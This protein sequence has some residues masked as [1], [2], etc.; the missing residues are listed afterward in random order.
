MC[1]FASL[2]AACGGADSS[3]PVTGQDTGLRLEIDSPNGESAFQQGDQAITYNY[4]VTNTGAQSLSGPVI[5]EDAPR[6]V[7]CPQLNS[8]GNFDN[9][10]D[11][12]ESVTCTASYT[13]G[14]QDRSAGSITTRARAIV[15]GV[16]S[17]ESTFTLGHTAAGPTRSAAGASPTPAV[18]TPSPAVDSTQT[19]SAITSPT[20]EAFAS[21]T[22]GPSVIPTATVGASVDATQTASGNAGT[23]PDAFAGTTQTPADFPTAT[24]GSSANVTA[25]VDTLNVID[26]AA[27]TDTILLPGVVPA[28]GTIRY[29]INAA[30]G[31]Q[32]SLNFIVTTSQL[33]VTVTAPDGSVVKTRELIMPWS[34]RLASAGDYLIE[35]QNLDSAAAQ[36]Y[37]LELRLTPAS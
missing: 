10:L 29:S 16:M 8:I 4:V 22:Q 19:P 27:G 2:L 18:M 31:Q 33:A 32:L 9:Q 28:G 37:L 13:P 12:N 21:A 6:M 17:N 24:A 7:I 35:V 3:V 11:F 26:L 34:G 1:L 20:P 5:V 30:Q 36:P 25:A 14:E 23:T 15:G